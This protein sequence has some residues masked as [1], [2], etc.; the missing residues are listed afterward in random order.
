MTDTLT[1]AGVL[2]A[3]ADWIE[4]DPTRWGREVLIDPDKGCRCALGAIA[5]AADP[6]DH[7]GDPFY[8]GGIFPDLYR[9]IRK[10]AVAAVDVLADYVTHELGAPWCNSKAV[11]GPDVVETIGGWND[12]PDRTPSEVVAALR[13]AAARTAVTQ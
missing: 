1:P 3:A 6:N 7:D 11:G 5:L 2:L 10:A 9:P 12:A 8:V 4:A 13:A